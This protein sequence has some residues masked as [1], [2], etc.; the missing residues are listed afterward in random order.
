VLV[1]ED[2]ADMARHLGNVLAADY[3]VAFAADGREG[4]EAAVEIA[5]DLVLT[6][7]MMPRMG[8]AELVEALR[9]RPELAETPILVLTARA[10][11]G[12]S[13]RMLRAGAQDY[14]LKPFERGELV[15]RV[16][17]LL[18]MTGTRRL[19]Q[20]ALESKEESLRELARMAAR[21]KRELEQAVEEKR[22]LLRELHHRVKGNLQTV[23][24]LLQLQ[25]REVDDERA[26]QT[27]EESRGRVA[28]MGLLHEKLYRS[29]APDRVEM[30]GYLRSLV[31]DV[32]KT[33][34][35]SG[36]IATELRTE[37]LAMPVDDAVA[38][39]LV[40]HELVTNAVRHAF[41][42]DAS[43]K[44]GVELR[45]EDGHGVLVVSDDGEGAAAPDGSRPAGVGLQL[46]DALVAQL[47]G[48]LETRVDD[49]TEVEIVF[50]LR[51]SRGVGTSGTGTRRGA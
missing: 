37:E 39:G 10:E 22:L 25:L 1:V 42:G 38:C 2:D 36:R 18:E 21:R 13:E 16:G 45:R 23:T 50:P 40:V 35:A 24:S 17:N 7:M 15:A 29:G 11:T 26:R 32:V 9:G 44:I 43:G 19:L 12:L 47:E 8:G 49:G 6:D 31:A 30:S 41:P 3:D 27:L 34:G 51:E 48:S 46:V 33:R 5:P 4:F 14:V 20:E 28:A